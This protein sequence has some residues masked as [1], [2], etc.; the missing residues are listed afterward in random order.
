MTE[1]PVELIFRLTTMHPIVRNS[2]CWT[3]SQ[4]A[5]HYVSASASVSDLDNVEN[6]WTYNNSEYCYYSRC[7]LSTHNAVFQ[8]DLKSRYSSLHKLLAD[9]YAQGNPRARRRLGQMFRQ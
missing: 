1:N 8:D 6:M 3:R 2:G 9:F 5:A 7:V 4:Q